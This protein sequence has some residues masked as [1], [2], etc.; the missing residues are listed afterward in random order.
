MEIKICQ[1]F[2]SKREHYPIEIFLRRKLILKILAIF[3]VFI[4]KEFYEKTERNQDYPQEDYDN[5][6]PI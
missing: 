6:I 1:K 2:L 3:Q 5:G 4:V